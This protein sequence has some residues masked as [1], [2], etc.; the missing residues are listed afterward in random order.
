MLRPRN[1]THSAGIRSITPL[2]IRIHIRPSGAFQQER[3]PKSGYVNPFILKI[4]F[5]ASVFI[6]TVN[7]T[8]TRNSAGNIFVKKMVISLKLSFI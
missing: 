1:F 7:N 5:A 4:S 2:V 3:F 8:L 6:H